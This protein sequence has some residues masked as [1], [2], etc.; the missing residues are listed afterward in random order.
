MV[1]ARAIAREIPAP[2]L[3]A[4]AAALVLGVL[5]TPLRKLIFNVPVLLTLGGALIGRKEAKAEAPVRAA[6]AKRKAPARKR[7]PAKK[8]G[9]A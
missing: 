1:D 4:G 2:Y 5:A 7:A 6:P 8:A 3:A 9:A